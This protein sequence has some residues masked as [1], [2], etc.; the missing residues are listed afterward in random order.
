MLGMVCAAGCI[1]APVLR[2]RDAGTS[3]A[4]ADVSAA[5]PDVVDAAVATDATDVVDAE[6]LEVPRLTRPLSFAVVGTT[7]PE[8]RWVLSER[9]TGA[10]VEVCE[11]SACARVAQTVDAQGNLVRLT[12]SLLYRAYFWR[13]RARYGERFSAWSRTWEFLVQ[14]NANAMVSWYG[15]TDFDRDGTADIVVGAPGANGGRGAVLVYRGK[16]DPATVPGAILQGALDER[17]V[18]GALTSG[19]VDGDGILDIVATGGTATTSGPRGGLHVVDFTNE[20]NGAPTMRRLPDSEFTAGASSL[21]FVGDMDGDGFGDVAVGA[22][23]AA[24]LQGELRILLGI[25]LRVERGEEHPRPAGDGPPKPWKHYPR[26]GGSEPR[27]SGRL[28]GDESHPRRRSPGAQREGAVTPGV[29]VHR[30]DAARRGGL[31][32]RGAFGIGDG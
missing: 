4:S 6:T 9:A 25:S 27:S 26:D 10:Q 2:P 23:A 8:L 3:E 29:A 19:D 11:D 21:A 13:V 18:G 12:A 30:G 14:G 5:T 7:Q 28:R 15:F 22:P 32:G 20:P 31:A 24:N 1:P 17:S 16:M